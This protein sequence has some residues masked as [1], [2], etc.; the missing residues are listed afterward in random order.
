MGNQSE[1][2]SRARQH[3]AE[4]MWGSPVE[5]ERRNRIKIALWAYAY[6]Y[7]SDSLID[8]ATF[9]DVAK[10]INPAIDTGHQVLDK[11]FREEFGPETGQ[12]IHKHPELDKVAALYTRLQNAKPRTGLRNVLREQVQPEAHE[13][14]GVREP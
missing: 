11:F 13:H 9:D 2:C 3:D 8:D 1:Q 14:N 7:Q 12:W 5:I 4:V 10:S 6:E